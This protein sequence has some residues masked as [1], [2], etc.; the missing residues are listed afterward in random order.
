MAGGSQTAQLLICSTTFE[1]QQFVV[2][3]VWHLC[4]SAEKNPGNAAGTMQWTIQMVAK[5]M[6]L[7]VDLEGWH[8]GK[9][10][11][12]V[13][14]S[15]TDLEKPRKLLHFLYSSV[16]VFKCNKVFLSC[17]R[18]HLQ[19][20]LYCNSKLYWVKSFICIAMSRLPTRD[21]ELYLHRQRHFGKILQQRQG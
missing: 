4:S 7:L 17:K 21:Q 3:C 20:N 10:V 12:A 19:N 13:F 15:S 1:K 8:H 5:L 18:P 11:T 14:E 9:V 16:Q 2:N 6:E